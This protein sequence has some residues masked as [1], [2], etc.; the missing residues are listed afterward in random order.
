MRKAIFQGTALWNFEEG[1]YILK[2]EKVLVTSFTVKTEI[3]SVAIE[4]PILF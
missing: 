4:C 2:K 1:H 3:S